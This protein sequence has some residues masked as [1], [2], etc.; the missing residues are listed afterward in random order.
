MGF[1]DEAMET[2]RSSWFDLGIKMLTWV[3][4]FGYYFSWYPAYRIRGGEGMVIF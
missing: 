4:V 2:G 3:G 1:W